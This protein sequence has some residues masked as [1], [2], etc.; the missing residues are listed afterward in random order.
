MMVLFCA[1]VLNRRPGVYQTLII[2]LFAIH[3]LLLLTHRTF[4]GF[5]FGARYAVDLIPYA[6][7]YLAGRELPWGW[8]KPCLLVMLAGLAFSIFGSLMIRLPG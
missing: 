1:D 2:L 8:K 3:L 4:G 5:Q 6:F 7:A